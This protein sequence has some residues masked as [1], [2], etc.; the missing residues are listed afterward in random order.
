M[1]SGHQR[2]SSLE[3]RYGRIFQRTQHCSKL[4]SQG[5]RGSGLLV[6]ARGAVSAQVEALSPFFSFEQVHRQF[7][8]QILISGSLVFP[9]TFLPDLSLLD[10]FGFGQFVESLRWVRALPRT[11]PLMNRLADLLYVLVASTSFEFAVMRTRANML[12]IVAK[13]HRANRAE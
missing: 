3:H 4:I 10:F 7:Y 1:F 9:R 11:F 13:G 5:G 12:P 2:I 8:N 6:Q